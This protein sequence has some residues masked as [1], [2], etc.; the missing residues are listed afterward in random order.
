M[1]PSRSRLGPGGAHLVRNETD[2]PARFLM[3]SSVVDYDIVQYPDSG[4]IGIRS[5]DLRLT[6]RPESGVDLDGEA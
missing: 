5:E 4:K 1:T 6:V 2:A 3:L